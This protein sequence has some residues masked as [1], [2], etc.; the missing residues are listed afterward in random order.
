MT[1]DIDVAMS[2]MMVHPCTRVL[3][4]T[5]LQFQMHFKGLNSL[6]NS[7][8]NESNS[9]IHDGN[10]ITLSEKRFWLMPLDSAVSWRCNSDSRDGERLT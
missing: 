6:T 4:G 9:G 3:K 10:R 8:A 7:A 2:G 5:V 1:Y